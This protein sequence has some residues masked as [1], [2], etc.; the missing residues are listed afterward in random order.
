MYD[1]IIV[2]AGPIGCKL[3]EL[4]GKENINTIILEE[5]PEIGKPAHCTGLVSHRIPKLSGA[6]SDVIVNKVKKASFYSFDKNYLELKS[7]K[8]VYVIDRVKFDEE[9]SE[10]AKNYVE[11]KTSTRFEDFKRK[12]NYIAVKTKKE[13]L[14]SKILIGAD[15]P[16]STVAYNARIKLPDNIL[17]GLQVRIKSKYKTDGVE[18]WFSK[19]ISSDFFG[20]VV[21]E[22][23]EWARV[24]IATSDNVVKHLNY[25]LNHRFGKKIEPKD[26]TAGRIR[27]G[28]IKDSVSS[29]VLLVGDAATQ[30]KPFSGGG[31]IYGLIGARVANEACIKA[32]EKEKYSYKFLKENYDEVWRQKLSWPITKGLLYSKII[33]SLSDNQLSF[34]FSTLNKTRMRKLLEFTDMDL[35]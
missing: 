32:F 13:I 23:E 35:L 33:H 24:G 4:L 17:T 11:I 29:N 6:S 27:F 8:K 10:L 9:L 19:E 2:G 15:G 7:R 5:H 30:V 26:N 31:L 28:L 18:L 3:G 12:R 20:W 1:A 21:P 22:N 16:N 25:F 34:L 14:K